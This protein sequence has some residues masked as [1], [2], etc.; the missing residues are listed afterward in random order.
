MGSLSRDELIDGAQREF[1]EQ[2]TVLPKVARIV[3]EELRKH[4]KRERSWKGRTDCDRLTAAFARLDANGILARENFSMTPTWGRGEMVELARQEA[5][6]GR[7]IRGYV[8]YNPQDLETVLEDRA[9]GLVFGPLEGD[10]ESAVAV[11]GEIIQ[12][13]EKEGLKTEWDG[14]P[15]FRIWVKV[16]WKKRRIPP[17]HR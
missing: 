16:D 13:L 9:L 3:D 4:A 6:K 14:N 5:G 15:F 12:V 10:A 11:G 7:Q 8:F 17:T 1:S 2:Q